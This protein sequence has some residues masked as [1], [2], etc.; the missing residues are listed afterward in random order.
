MTAATAPLPLATLL[1]HAQARAGGRARRVL[2]WAL[3]VSLAAH[4]AIT[5]WPVEPPAESDATPLAGV[6][7]EGMCWRPSASRAAS[8]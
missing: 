4:V 5:L 6:S 8:S 3:A 7:N 2:A 1:R